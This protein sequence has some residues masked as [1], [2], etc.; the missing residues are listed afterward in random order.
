MKRLKTKRKSKKRKLDKDQGCSRE[1]ESEIVSDE[2]SSEEIQDTT[3]VNSKVDKESP[4][5][6]QKPAEEKSRDE[7]ME[8]YL[9]DLLL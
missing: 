5:C 3:K 1:S 4:W 7:E 9:K 8:E 2:L 6:K